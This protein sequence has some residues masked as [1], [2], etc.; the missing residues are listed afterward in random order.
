MLTDDSWKLLSKI[1][2]LT[3]RIYN[4][5]E[6]RMPLEGILFRI[7]TGIPWRDLPRQFGEWNTVFR[8]FNLWS[9][10]GVMMEIFQFLSRFNDP[11]WL[12]ID[13]SIVSLSSINSVRQSICQSATTTAPILLCWSMKA[14]VAKTVPTISLCSKLYPKLLT[15]VLWGRHC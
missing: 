14:T 3:G 5:P 12:F 10:K 11:Q 1:M 6:H 9:K 13:A 8:R 15:L 4:K 2:H 7:R